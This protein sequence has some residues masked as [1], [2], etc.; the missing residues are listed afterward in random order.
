VH[1]REQQNFG[2]KSQ[3]GAVQSCCEIK[4]DR[5]KLRH[6]DDPRNGNDRR[7]YDLRN[8]AGIGADQK[9]YR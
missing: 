3:D 6:E 4:H 7:N 2:L 1:D 9:V 8:R 5:P